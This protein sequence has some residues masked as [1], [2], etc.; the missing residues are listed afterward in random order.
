METLDPSVAAARPLVDAETAASLAA[1][2]WGRRGV[3]TELPSERDRV[4]RIDRAAD[5]GPGAGPDDGP[6]T[7]PDDGPAILKIANALETAA[8]I[9]A[10]CAMLARVHAAGTGT[11]VPLPIPTSDGLPLVAVELGGRTH[12]AR[13]QSFVPGTPLPDVTPFG[14]GLQEGLGRLVASVDRALEGLDTPARERSIVWDPRGAAALIREHASA[15]AHPRRRALLE[16]VLEGVERRVAPRADDLPVGLIHNDAHGDNVIVDPGATDASPRI[17]G[18]VDFG[19]ALRTWTIAGLATASAYAGFGRRDPVATFARLARG[20]AAVRPPT[21]A[22]ADVLF[23]LIRLRLALSVTI[24]A[25]RAVHEPENA[26]LSTSE[27]PAWALLEALGSTSADLARYRLR[28]AAGLDP[29]PASARVVAAIRAAAPRAGPVLDPDPRAVSTAVI[30]LSVESGDDGGTFD[31]ADHAAFGRFLL[32]RMRDA[33]ARVGIGRY[34]E[35]RWWYTT[36]EFVTPADD[37][38]EWRTVHLGIDLFAGAGTP[39]RSPLAGRITSVADNGTRLDYG[40]T[41]IVEHRLDAAAERRDGDAAGEPVRFFTLYGH[42][43]PRTLDEIRPG[44]DVAAGDV[45]G[46]LGAPPRNG[47]WAPHLHFQLIVDPLDH[48]GTFPGVAAPSQRDVW[49][50]LSPDPNLLLGIPGDLATP[51]RPDEAALRGRRARHLGP[52]LSLSYRRPL[53]IVR[54]RGARLYDIDGQPHLDCVNNVAHVGHAHPRITEAA[55]RQLGILNTNTRYLHETILAY[56]ETLTARFPDPLSVCFFVC[57]GTEANELALRMSRTFTRKTGAVVVDGAYHGNSS[58]VIN[59]SPYKFD[60]PGGKGVRPWVRVVPMP[61]TYRGVYRA[62]GNATPEDL[63]ALGERYAAHVAEAFASLNGGDGM[64]GS[65]K[66][67]GGAAFFCESLLSCGGQIPLP[68]GYLAA[69]ARHARDAGAV[70][71]ADEVQVGFGRVGSHFWGFEESGIVPDIVTLGKPI[72]NG[73]PL[74]AVV[75][76]PEIATAFDNGMEYFNTFGGNPVSCAI[77]LEVLRIIEDEGLQENATR[78]GGR[79]ETGLRS[80]MDRHPIIG[81]VRGRGLFLG[82]ELVADRETR[83]PAAA[84]AARTVER[85]RDRGILLST[86]G[87]A[88]DVIKIKPPL[89][90]SEADANLVLG[91]LDEIL[92][93]SWAK[94]PRPGPR[95]TVQGRRDE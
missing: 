35:V 53:H 32:D 4:F 30:D 63:A 76:T 62:D 68:P 67:L 48:E 45:V 23:D 3:A 60:G 73:H 29:V 15:I 59:L 33:G 37:V 44:T 34:D 57:S 39:V 41:V 50:A 78:V 94:P 22:E 47:G 83:E 5:D 70:V 21:A 51:A 87:P 11:R 66:P 58:S 71:V 92:S 89:V 82:L 61:D 84:H 69:A 95:P 74:A 24:S 1:T 43:A 7:G 26:Y 28:D 31:P 93:E 20:Y 6:G 40:P 88:H 75:T 64:Y 72:G 56:A 81:D 2:L 36:P 65:V 12:I 54:G 8:A 80:L 16:A 55:Q 91:R 13:L 14:P 19:D 18:L 90:F 49:R 86:D 79:L 10:E 9:E 42:L 46:W 27:A 17:V 77:G 38:D 52:S 25:V 85:M